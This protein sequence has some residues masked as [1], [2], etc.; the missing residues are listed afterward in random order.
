[1]VVYEEILE[2]DTINEVNKQCIKLDKTE[3]IANI[4]YIFTSSGNSLKKSNICTN[5][6]VHMNTETG[7]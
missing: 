2:L 6:T 5:S 4:T 7:H 1:M 3:P